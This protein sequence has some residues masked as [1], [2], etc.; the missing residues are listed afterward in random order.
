[1]VFRCF[2][3]RVI[4]LHGVDTKTTKV[5]SDASSGN[6]DLMINKLNTDYLSRSGQFVSMRS[7]LQRLSPA[8]ALGED[9]NLPGFYY[10]VG[11]FAKNLNRR[12][13]KGRMGTTTHQS[14]F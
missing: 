8:L 6:A 1:M 12:T 10:T 13:T 11:V 4:G 2:V 9:W 5:I 14:T 3:I 7:K